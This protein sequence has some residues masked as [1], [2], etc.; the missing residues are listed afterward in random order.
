M[1]SG[2]L[3]IR[4]DFARVAPWHPSK[5]QYKRYQF[6]S[7]KSFSTMF[8]RVFLTGG[9]VFHYKSICCVFASL[10]PKQVA[11][12]GLLM[13]AMWPLAHRCPRMP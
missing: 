7:C 1:T 8:L 12:E 4:Q 11:L 13:V 10:L 9:G 3:M 6:S 2:L 5:V